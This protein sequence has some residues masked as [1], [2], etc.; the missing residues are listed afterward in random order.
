LNLAIEAMK[1]TGVGREL[2]Y[3]SDAAKVKTEPTYGRM[4]LRSE[5]NAGPCGVASYF[6]SSRRLRFPAG[7]AAAGPRATASF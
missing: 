1:D 2:F 5:G 6:F 7:I 3:A 4:T